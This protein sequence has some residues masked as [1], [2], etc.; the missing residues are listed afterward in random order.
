MQT[1]RLQIS[2][3]LLDV[4][5]EIES[6]SKNSCANNVSNMRPRPN[7]LPSANTQIEPITAK[8]SVKFAT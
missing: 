5:T 1:P 3:E 6:I 4:I 8:A 7:W 2:M